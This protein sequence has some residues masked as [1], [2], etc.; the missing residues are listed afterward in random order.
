MLSTK[1]EDLYYSVESIKIV[2]GS[3]IG[4]D[5]KWILYFH[6]NHRYIELRTNELHTP[7]VFRHRYLQMFHSPVPLFNKDTWY[8]FLKQLAERAQV[9]DITDFPENVEMARQICF[10]L[11]S[12]GANDK[13]EDLHCMY[14]NKDGFYYVPVKT[15]KSII[16]DL[17][18]KISIKLLKKILEKLNIKKEDEIDECYIK[19]LAP[20]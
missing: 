10:C 17:H 14:D 1:I 5:S 7:T 20:F 15:I 6:D 16:K 19:I 3:T 18:L 2:D 4:E 8:T 13:P 11:W 9:I 12:V